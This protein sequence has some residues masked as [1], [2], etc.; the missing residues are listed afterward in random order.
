MLLQYATQNA[1][2]P[3]RCK[4][5]ML[6]YQCSYNVSASEDILIHTDHAR[7]Q[8]N[9][10]PLPL[11]MRGKGLIFYGEHYPRSMSRLRQ[12]SSIS[13]TSST[14]KDIRMGQ[15]FSENRIL[16]KSYRSLAIESTVERVR[17]RTKH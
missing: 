6:F 2:K 12:S 5:S 14:E 15:G 13:E 17:R 7:K 8:Q 4:K 10:N 3:I 11:G 1:R 9:R 16:R